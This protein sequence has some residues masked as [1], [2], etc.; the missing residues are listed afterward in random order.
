MMSVRAVPGVVPGEV[1]RARWGS[2]GF[3]PA[4]PRRA[5]MG[6]AGAHQ[7]TTIVAAAGQGQASPE[8][9][10]RPK[11]VRA[12]RRRRAR[13]PA[14]L[15]RPHFRDLAALSEAPRRQ[16]REGAPRRAQLPGSGLARQGQASL[17]RR[18]RRAGP[19]A[20]SGL[21]PGSQPLPVAIFG[22]VG[23]R[24]AR[25]GRRGAACALVRGGLRWRA[26]GGHSGCANGP[27]AHSADLVAE[28]GGPGRRGERKGR[29]GAGRD[30]P[31]RR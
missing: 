22:R 2:G 6:V 14:A 9:R 11:C 5:C 18:A 15:P 12:A 19:R 29:A 31:Q 26:R 13:G 4:C 27:R 21:Y 20:R 28:Q 24:R 30:G 23:R 8:V 16:A 3:P 1:C 17:D 10:A 25:E 7:A